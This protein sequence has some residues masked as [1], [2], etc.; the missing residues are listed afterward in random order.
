MYLGRASR[1]IHKLSD[2][3]QEG[4][5]LCMPTSQGMQGLEGASL[6]DILHQLR[7]HH[8]GGCCGHNSF[9]NASVACTSGQPQTAEG[10][11][12]LS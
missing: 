10:K 7:G 4:G 2:G 9:G 6:A 12:H 8:G 11:P 5:A 3:K 1:F